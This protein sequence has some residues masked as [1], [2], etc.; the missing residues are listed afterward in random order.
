MQLGHHLCMQMLLWCGN[1]ASCIGVHLYAD[2]IVV[3]YN[4]DHSIDN[5]QRRIRLQCRLLMHYHASQYAHVC[6]P[7]HGA[8]KLSFIYHHLLE[9]RRLMVIQWVC[10][11]MVLALNAYQ[12]C[13][14]HHSKPLVQR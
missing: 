3:C 2:C 11:Q 4:D 7:F 12:V 5:D 13:L 8:C 6:Y 10:F 1:C 14:I 9:V